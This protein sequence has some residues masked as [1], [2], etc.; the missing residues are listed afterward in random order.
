MKILHNEDQERKC[1]SGP[2][3]YNLAKI[4]SPMKYNYLLVFIFFLACT[5][6]LTNNKK[7]LIKKVS[8]LK[9]ASQP[10]VIEINYY[11][12]CLEL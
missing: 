12:L 4:P 5:M 3:N 7:G 9:K 1:A 2:G 8:I 11:K 6:R 10:N